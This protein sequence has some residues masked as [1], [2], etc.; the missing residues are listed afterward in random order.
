MMSLH[1]MPMLVN[2]IDLDVAIDNAE[3]HIAL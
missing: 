3:D 1:L 2:V